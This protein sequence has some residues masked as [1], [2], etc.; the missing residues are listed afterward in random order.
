MIVYFRNISPSIFLKGLSILYRVSYAV[1]LNF[2]LK[3]CFDIYVSVLLKVN[4]NLLLI[5]ILFILLTYKNVFQ[6]CELKP[7][8]YTRTS[9]SKIYMY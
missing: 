6:Q 9:F 1:Y 3:T 7:C 8:E 2:H 4:V 5:C